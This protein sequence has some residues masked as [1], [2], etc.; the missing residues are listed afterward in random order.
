MVEALEKLKMPSDTELMQ[1]SIADLN[2]SSISFEDCYHALHNVL[3]LVES[4]SNANDLSRLGGLAAVIRELSNTNTEIRTISAWI[5]GKASQNNPVVQKQIMELGALPIL[6]K[7]V[8]S[9]F[10]EEALKSLYAISAVIS[11]NPPSQDLFYSEAGELMLLD[12]LNDSS[13]NVRLLRKSASL[14]ADLAQFQVQNCKEEKLPSIK[15]NLM[16]S[17]VNVATLSTDLDLQEKALLGIKNLVKHLI[18]SK[19]LE[20]SVCFE[21]DEALLKMGEQL[22]DL[23]GAEYQRDYASDIGNLIESIPFLC[24]MLWLFFGP[25]DLEGD[26]HPDRDSHTTHLPLPH[27]LCPSSLAFSPLLPSAISRRLAAAANPS[28]FRFLFS[29]P[30]S[31]KLR[32]RNSS[33]FVVVSSS[34]AVIVAVAVSSYIS[35]L[36]Y[37]DRSRDLVFSHPINEKEQQHKQNSLPSISSSR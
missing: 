22:K 26:S 18:S 30:S 10:R 33:I 20:P 29:N 25:L 11:N 15:I 36:A 31:C 37:A 34:I 2:N 17:L 8:K 14:V 21:L 9:N 16:K 13:T 35:A 27:M 1:A 7:M 32:L 6:M 24:W 23:K 19:A 28:P 4:L 5:L 3:N 12:L